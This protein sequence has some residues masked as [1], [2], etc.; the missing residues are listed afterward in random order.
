MYIIIPGPHLSSRSHTTMKT[1]KQVEDALKS[2]SYTYD[3]IFN[4][5]NSNHTSRFRIIQTEIKDLWW[6]MTL[7]YIGSVMITVLIALAILEAI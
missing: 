1:K 2:K 5:F 3:E 4:K 6:A 7:V